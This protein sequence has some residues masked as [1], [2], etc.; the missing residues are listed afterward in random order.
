MYK[1]SYITKQRKTFE[2]IQNKLNGLPFSDQQ[3]QQQQQHDETQQ[4][5][6]GGRKNGKT[7]LDRKSIYQSAAPFY[8]HPRL[9][10][11]NANYPLRQR[12]ATTK[13]APATSS[14]APPLLSLAAERTLQPPTQQLTMLRDDVPPSFGRVVTLNGSE[15]RRFFAA[16]KCSTGVEVELVSAYNGYVPDPEI[17]DELYCM[18][19][20]IDDLKLEWASWSTSLEA[21]NIWYRDSE[22]TTPLQQAR[23]SVFLSFLFRRLS[24]EQQFH[25][26]TARCY[27]DPSLLGFFRQTSA[28]PWVRSARVL[29]SDT[30]L[31]FGARNQDHA[32]AA[33]A[34]DVVPFYT[35]YRTGEVP[36]VLSGTAISE[37]LFSDSTDTERFESP[38]EQR[39]I[40]IQDSAAYAVYEYVIPRAPAS[41]A[42]LVSRSSNTVLELLVRMNKQDFE[43][44]L[45]TIERQQPPPLARST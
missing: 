33:A 30:F 44:A 37:R 12:P 34:R 7:K 39:L 27:F 26:I 24:A 5:D 19:F 14:A 40:G 4:Q 36:R 11:E 31:S 1:K 38:L 18:S 21:L 43:E 10:Y 22:R 29:R 41:I 2:K 20:L 28:A 17:Q 15:K 3:Q 35:L 45:Y 42:L 16:I 32:A 25:D 13:T 6:G 8:R 9:F 23:A